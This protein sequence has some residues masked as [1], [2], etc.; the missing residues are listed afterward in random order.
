MEPLNEPRTS[1]VTE[2]THRPS[3][4][5]RTVSRRLPLT[6]RARHARSRCPPSKSQHPAHDSVRREFERTD[7]PARARTIR[8]PSTTPGMDYSL[9]RVRPK[10]TLRPSR[11]FLAR[12]HPVRVSWVSLAMMNG[13]CPWET[14][15]GKDKLWQDLRDQDPF[16]FEGGGTRKR[17]SRAGP[18]RPITA[19]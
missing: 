17:G 5:S 7:T 8:R 1:T 18:W 15:S 12:S 16:W 2:A 9:A 11:H 6:T 19:S 10:A 4:L 3:A 13:V 14:T